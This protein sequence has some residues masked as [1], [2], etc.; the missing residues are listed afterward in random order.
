VKVV[1]NKIIQIEESDIVNGTFELPEGVTVIEDFACSDCTS[2]VKL[3]DGIT[4]VGNFAFADCFSLKGIPDS[5]TIFKHR[6]FENCT[7]LKVLHLGSNVK[8]IEYT[9]FKNTHIQKIITPY[10]EIELDGRSD[11]RNIVL[12]YLYLYANSILKN[13]YESVNDF[14]ISTRDYSLFDSP[15]LFQEDFILKFKNLF[16]KL[17]K[18]WDINDYLFEEL[19]LKTTEKF[20]LKIWNEIK[21]LFDW[22]NSSEMSHAFAEIME[23]F[24]V[25]EEDSKRDLRVQKLKFLFNEAPCLTMRDMVRIPAKTEFFYLTAEKMYFLQSSVIPEEFQIYLSTEMSEEQIHV[26]RKLTGT[27]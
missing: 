14:Y 5:I 11:S 24:G 3:L 8:T 20:Q 27:M 9:A 19:S 10:G 15:V 1:E 2:L 6:A 7:S 13:P 4:T 26:I 21:N 16:F 22:E 17:R 12:H 25:F 18:E 23:V